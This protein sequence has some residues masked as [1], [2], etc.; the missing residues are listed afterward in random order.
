MVK[1]Q[2]YIIVLIVVLAIIALLVFSGN[3]KRGSKRLTPLAGIAFGCTLA[4]LF[5][6]EEKMVGYCLF[7]CGIILAIIDMI[8]KSKGK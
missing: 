3:P 7:G 6:G 5:F 4:G 1:S 2:A 8:L